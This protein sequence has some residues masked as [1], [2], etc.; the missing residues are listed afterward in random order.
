MPVQPT[1]PGVYIQEIP[2]GVR[3]ITGVS[4]SIA[5][6]FGTA[7][8]GP[9]NK[10][11]T[12]TSF[13]DFERKFGGLASDSEM[14][15]AVKQFYLN[16]G[17]QAIITRLVASARKA[18]L[19]LQTNG[20]D[21]VILIESIQGGK[22]G[23]NIE[24]LV[25]YN[26][27][28]PLNT[29]NLI[30]KYSNATNP[31]ENVVE[32]FKDL[33]MNSDN[34]RYFKTVINRASNLISADLS[35]PT[36]AVPTGTKGFV[37]SKLVN[38]SSIDATHNT[39]RIKINNSEPIS[40]T[41]DLPAPTTLTA[42]KSQIQTKV[43]ALAN[44]AAAISGFTCSDD[45]LILKLESGEGGENS[46][47]EILPGLSNDVASVLKLGEM[48]GGTQV[49]ATSIIRPK[50][51]PNQASIK[52]G[53]ISA[54]PANLPSSANSF[55]ISIDGRSPRDVSIGITDL[56][57][58]SLS[59][60]LEDIASRIQLA[61]RALNPGMIGFDKFT[62]L[63]DSVD[64]K[65]IFSSGSRGSKSSISISQAGTDLLVDKLELL[66]SSN[67]LRTPGKDEFL[68]FGSESPITDSNR[69]ITYSGNQTNRTG[70]FTLEEIDLFNI[71]C[72]PGI[73]DSG[74]L[75]EAEAYCKKRRAFLIIDAQESDNNPDKIKIA[76]NNLPKSDSSAVYFPW[77]KVPDPL[78]GGQLRTS[79]PSGTMAGIYAKIDT[80][81]GVWKSPAG[82]ET[83]LRG[84]QGLSYILTNEENGLLNPLGINCLRR[85]PDSG[86]VSWG[87]RTLRGND[88][89]ADEYKYVPIRRTA[90]FIEESLF[91]GLQWVVFEA[92][93]ENLWSQI[94][95][96]VGAF[97]HSLFTK[98]AF[99]G[100]KNDAYF[101]KCD[102]E[103]TTQ[104]DINNGIVNI[105]VGFAPLKPAEFVII[106]LQQIA[107]NIPV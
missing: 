3:T 32:T 16:G 41:I 48:F 68:Q 94:R 75:A 79:P 99:Q 66:S 23:N 69:Y 65:L 22:Y 96:N 82:T 36:F 57:G 26:T 45:G 72:L 87:A 102:A 51:M 73:S 63:R 53:D 14:S 27:P 12:I 20:G 37:T 10:A 30:A 70:L 15:Y 58:T 47:V 62:C 28:N 50:E 17:T 33:S 25:D 18:N 92:N 7:N 64:N 95:L 9:I 38:L 61:V 42:L 71:M 49:D 24:I 5:A 98:G 103:T 34:I 6:F 77:I 89:L 85:F 60:R 31:S 44:G 59:V 91:R 104:T 56:N 106:S 11:V 21:D 78:N 67:P 83:N 101:V 35:N 19:K 13:A 29:F 84:V 81:R 1:Y 46:S 93:D 2:S 76:I 97:M 52:S 40:I 43:Q 74:I 55:S 90:Y 54:A 8:K 80:N 100:K 86:I 88:S 39:F 107:G 105:V 4:T